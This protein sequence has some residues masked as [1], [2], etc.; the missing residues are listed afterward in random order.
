MR[1]IPRIPTVTRRSIPRRIYRA[2]CRS[3]LPA[4]GIYAFLFAAIAVTKWGQT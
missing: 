3:W 1:A 2:M 4:I